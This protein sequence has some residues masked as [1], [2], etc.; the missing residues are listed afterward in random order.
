VPAGAVITLGSLVE[1]AWV[2]QGD[3]VEIEIGGLGAARVRF[4]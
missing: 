2:D 4:V 1:T 3:N